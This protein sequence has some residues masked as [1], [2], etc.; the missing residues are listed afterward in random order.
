[1]TGTR[2]A[3]GTV[4][5]TVTGAVSGS[6]SWT[7]T[8]TTTSTST[9]TQTTT[10]SSTNA[11]TARIADD[12]G[13]TLAVP[14]AANALVKK[15]SNGGLGPSSVSDDGAG[16]VSVDNAA[17]GSASVVIK[18]GQGAGQYE[19]IDFSHDGSIKW[20][21]RYTGGSYHDALEFSSQQGGTVA[22]LEND[23]F[24]RLSGYIQSYNL[25]SDGH[26]LI[27]LKKPAAPCGAGQALTSTSDTTTTCV[28]V[29]GAGS[30]SRPVSVCAIG[31]VLT[32]YS[33]G[34]TTCVSNGSGSSIA[35]AGGSCTTYRLPM[36][37]NSSS[38]ANSPITASGSDVYVDGSVVASNID[39]NGNTTGRAAGDCHSDGTN[40]PTAAT[41]GG[42]PDNH[43]IT[44]NNN[45]SAVTYDNRGRVTGAQSITPAWIGALGQPQRGQSVNSGSVAT[46]SD[47]SWADVAVVSVSTSGGV[48]EAHGSTTV[49]PSSAGACY[50]RIV[51]LYGSTTTVVGP[52]YVSGSSSGNLMNLATTGMTESPPAG[53][54][55]VR[56]QIRATTGLTCIA[57]ANQSVLWVRRDT[58]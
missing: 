50:A 19:G 9:S 37:T 12:V 5:G 30:L 15:T 34:V 7:T 22:R 53:A 54:Y 11:A 48:L 33:D 44:A 36:F 16:A 45:P 28:D 27:D 46:A 10:G 3:T 17:V 41:L 56:L 8:G 29:G 23:G 13:L 26:A 51:T 40:C 14:G 35:C 32:T 57:S 24:F 55:T 2:T 42:T 52:T 18:G 25:T 47:G 6:G 49:Y 58:M 21:L 39:I 1:L 31:E 4:A 43:S 20:R 38:V